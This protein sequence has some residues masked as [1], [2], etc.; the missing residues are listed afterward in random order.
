M[1]L[2]I[3]IE[4][5]REIEVHN[6]DGLC[7]E[8]YCDRTPT[9][10]LSISIGPQVCYVPLCSEHAKKAEGVALKMETRRDEVRRK[11]QEIQARA[12]AEM[13]WRSKQTEDDGS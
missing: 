4:S 10:Y 13:D 6:A 9:H 12:W 1:T 8:R 11:T 3:E 7:A 2:R 5:I